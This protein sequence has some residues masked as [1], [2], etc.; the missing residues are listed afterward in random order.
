VAEES[1]ACASVHLAFDHLGLGVDS[2]GAA[3]V[4]REGERG[5]SGLA[6]QVEAAGEGVQV[7]RLAARAA[8]IH[9]CR[10]L[11]LRGSGVSRPAKERTRLARAVISGQAAVSP[12]RIS[13]WPAVGLDGRVSR[14]RAARRD[15]RGARSASARPWERYWTSRVRLPW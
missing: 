2:L 5:G 7:G 1:E 8:V 4:V 12:V 10:R 9:F 11:A 15:D 6:V 14:S 3:V 13:C